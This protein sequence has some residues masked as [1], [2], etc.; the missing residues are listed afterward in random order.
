MTYIGHKSQH[1]IALVITLA[2]VSTAFGEEAAPDLS[3]GYH[4]GGAD[5]CFGELLPG[6]SERA[7][8]WWASSGWK[9]SPTRKLPT[10]QGEAIRI[11]AARNEAE[12]AQLVIS[13]QSDLR[14]LSVTPGDLRGP[15][16]ALLP[17][18]AVEVLRVRYVNVTEP[19]D[20]TGVVGLWPDPLPP[21]R[22]SLEAK[23]GENLPLWVRVTVPKGT[24]AGIY[25]GKLMLQAENWS[26][27]VPL[28]VEVFG[29]ELPDQM[30]CT[31]A[32]GFRPDLVYRY[33]GLTEESD[34]RA[35]LA[36]YWENLSD[37]HIS[38]YDP[39]P[40]DPFVVDWPKI[41]PTPEVRPEVLVPTIRW[42]AWDQ[43]VTE[44]FERYH[45]RT[46]RLPMVGM[47]SGTFHSRQE[48]E[49]L[50][51]A[52]DTPQYQAAF[53]AY[54][55]AVQEHLREKGWLDEVYVYWFD[56]PD[57]KDYEFVMNG[58]RKLKEAAPD[59]PRML[60]E[61]VKGE[62]VGG[63]NIWC[64]LSVSYDHS[65]AEERRK[66]GEK[67]WWYV[68]TAPPAPYCTLFIDH[69]ATE[70]RVWLWQTWQ[71]KID[72][73]LV[74]K[75]NYW[76]SEPAYPDK[77]H[78]QNPYE[79]PMGWMM[80]YDTP[81]GVRKKW[82]NGDG[83]FIY[84]PEAAADGK[85]GQPVLEGPVDS[86]RWEML[87]DGI[88]DY[89]YLAILKR[90]LDAKRDTLDA[91]AAEYEA[92]LVVPEEI[93]RSMTEFTVDPAPIESRRLSVARAIEELGGGEKPSEPRP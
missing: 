2:L 21:I 82:G 1:S 76:H 53:T 87:R 8:L 68:C 74:W 80:G 3:G 46:L 4:G 69:P 58:F 75:L 35:V 49:L 66:A 36:K 78:P 9:I 23:G 65:S 57:P 14:G 67:F 19:T 93:T 72:G 31:T 13:P 85:P 29:F 92:L 39:A 60:T 24:P 40:L 48:P 81:L 12:A 56:E 27:E 55:R 62:L 42:S 91:K 5:C 86:I 79:D 51:Y 71:R 30:T 64:P 47:G 52:E 61:E 44:A 83:R 20:P 45:F 33:H 77:D 84:P 73:I 16:G 26:A 18:H 59:I 70:L 38:P 25:S 50:G 43:A 17:A 90:L 54:G 34:K 63:P 7:S 28:Q 10:S 32:F 15:S 11:S 22:D 37:H 6:S 88:E 89:E 41:E